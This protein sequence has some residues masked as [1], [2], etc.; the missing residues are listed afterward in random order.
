MSNAYVYRSFG[1]A[2][3]S[4]IEL[5]GLA[6]AE[7]DVV[8]LLRIRHGET[9]TELADAE[10]SGE[11]LGVGYQT[12]PGAILITVEGVARFYVRR[13]TDITVQ[14]EP[15]TDADNLRVYLM[16]SAFGAVL[17]QRGL[18]PLH[19][20]A[21]RV[22]DSAVA[23][24]GTS[25]AGKS[26][27]AAFLGERGYDVVCDDLCPVSMHPERG[28][29]V[30]PGFPRIK[31]WI[32]AM[33]ALGVS[34]EGVPRVINKFDKFE[35]PAAIQADCPIPL[36]RVYVLERSAEDGPSGVSIEKLDEAR[37]L[38]VLLNNTYRYEFLKGLGLRERHFRT[39]VAALRDVDV[40]RLSRQWDLAQL[41]V[42]LEHL[43]ADWTEPGITPSSTP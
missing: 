26:T 28:A 3:S 32:D 29:V 33:E 27:L 34:T 40:C 24:V 25:G 6:H 1:L 12:Q 36:R 16:G 39:C 7:P 22:G 15:D 9:P 20:S 30:Q 21:I 43:A 31:I 11:F 13:G 17:Q 14:S 35:L 37:S 10:D 8:P 2:F 42:V 41:D 4:E 23:F 38:E 18:I 5:P 19:A